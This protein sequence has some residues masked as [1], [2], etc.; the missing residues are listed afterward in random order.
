MR[1]HL[2]QF[3]SFVAGGI[4]VLKMLKY[5]NG[6]VQMTMCKVKKVDCTDAPWIIPLRSMEP[7]CVFQLIVFILL[8]GSLSSAFQAEADRC[9]RY[10]KSSDKPATVHHL[11][12]I[13]ELRDKFKSSYWTH[14]CAKFHGNPSYS[15]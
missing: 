15:C 7:F 5:M 14:V 10:R 12:R 6:N 3:T 4:L 1:D 13:K 2:W 8:F 9:L 11:H